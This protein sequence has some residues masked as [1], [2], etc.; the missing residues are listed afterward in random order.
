MLLAGIVAIVF[1][2]VFISSIQA[3]S[4]EQGV[5]NALRK[6]GWFTLILVVILGIF[7][8]AT[9]PKSPYFQFADETPVKVI[10][11][12]AMQFTFY[13]SEKDIDPENPADESIELPSNQLVEFRVTSFDV[14]HG[15]AVYDPQ[16]RLVTQVQAMPGYVN[17]LRC[18]FTA[19]GEYHILC[20]EYCGMG[21][22]VMQTTFKVI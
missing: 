11:A 8:T 4:E 14:N 16:M 21:H 17:R 3:G 22:P 5:K 19:P 12:G 2:Y 9:I 6:R 18:K 1:G 7:A 20:L 13:L 15:F 10:H